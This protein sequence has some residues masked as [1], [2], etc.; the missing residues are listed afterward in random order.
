MLKTFTISCAAGLAMMTAAVAGPTVSGKSAPAVAPMPAPTCE[1]G[2]SYD[3]L[4]VDWSHSWLDG[5]A[6]D[7]NGV[8]VNLHKTIVD[9]LFFHGSAAWTDSTGDDWGFTAGLGYALPLMKNIDLV[10]EAGGFWSDGSDSGY[11]IFPHLRG[12]WGC[13]ELHAGAK[14]ADPSD[15]D[16]FWEAH[17][18]AFYQIA[19]NTDVHVGGIFSEFGDTLLVGLRY[20]F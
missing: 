11:Y 1:G 9:K 13:F 7:L 6:D 8:D 2:I 17:V 19:Q 10:A 20:K 3:N 18:N 4:S 15:G 16:N 12:K 5:G 14:F